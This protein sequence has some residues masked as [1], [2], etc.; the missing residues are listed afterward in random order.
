MAIF[1]TDVL[2]VYTECI[3][4]NIGRR[5]KITKALG[6]NLKTIWEH[7]FQKLRDS[8]EMKDSLNR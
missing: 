1:T 8:V 5:G 4:G 6:F 2:C 3:Y 7:D